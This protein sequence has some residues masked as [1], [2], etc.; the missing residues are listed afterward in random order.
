MFSSE[1]QYV[2]YLTQVDTNA[3]NGNVDQWLLW[4]QSSMI[5][6]VRDVTTK[7]FQE[8]TKI[9]RKDWVK[10]RCGM[11]VLCI[12]MTYWTYNSE[13]AIEGGAESLN[14]YCLKLNS[15]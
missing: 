7:S 14:K 5:E 6:S 2:N 10:N 15:S 3:A 11:A 1:G 8:Y 12:S 9:K 4:T 13:A